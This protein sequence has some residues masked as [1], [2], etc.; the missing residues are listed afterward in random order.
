MYIYILHI[1]GTAR[2]GRPE[3]DRE[4]ERDTHTYVHIYMYTY[5][6][7]TCGNVPSFHCRGLDA[8][9]FVVY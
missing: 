8:L 9:A 4:R 5:H 7:K 3:G 6:F 1:P 2:A